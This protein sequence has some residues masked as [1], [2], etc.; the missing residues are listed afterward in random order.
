ML[1]CWGIQG[2]S[3]A[4]YSLLTIKELENR[5]LSNPVNPMQFYLGGLSVGLAVR[6]LREPSGCDWYLGGGNV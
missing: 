3:L 2:G 4:D 5:F 6:M 1:E